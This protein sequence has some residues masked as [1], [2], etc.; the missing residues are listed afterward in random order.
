MVKKWNKYRRRRIKNACLMLA[1]IFS[2]L[3][4]IEETTS[5][6][7]ISMGS[8]WASC[9]L[10]KAYDFFFG[11][12]LEAM[13]QP[14]VKETSEIYISYIDEELLREYYSDGGQF[15]YV[16]NEKMEE[17]EDTRKWETILSDEAEKKLTILLG[18][19]ELET[20]NIYI[21]L[22]TENKYRGTAIH[23]F[24]HYLD[25]KYGYSDS[26]EFIDVAEVEQEK[27][28][29]FD[30]EVEIDR[31]EYF[32]ETYATYLTMPHYLEKA[33]PNTYL[34]MEKLTKGM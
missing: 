4:L 32:A 15:V 25:Y 22:R 33:A 14:D 31:K 34:Y 17:I 10:V 6:K 5:Y 9:N 26:V 7:V 30:A 13:L 19:Y 21:N 2:I 16:T 27:F 18:C 20:K 1:I 12:C 28:S 23:E 8:Y 11:P 24:A 3:F 29:L